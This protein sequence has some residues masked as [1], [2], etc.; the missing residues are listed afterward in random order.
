MSNYKVIKISPSADGSCS[1]TACD[2]PFS[3]SLEEIYGFIN[4]DTISI[5]SAV[6]YNSIHGTDYSIVIDDNGKIEHKP[7]N[8][9]ATQMYAPLYDFIV[10]DVLIMRRER[11]AAEEPDVYPFEEQE[12]SDLMMN[13]VLLHSRLS[14]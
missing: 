1:V 13:L 2:V 7:I 11:T 4:C 9:N 12:A 3:L 5:V 14:K 8:L 10:G 6:N